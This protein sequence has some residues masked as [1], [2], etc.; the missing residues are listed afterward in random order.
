[1]K[2]IRVGDFCHWPKR[3]GGSPHWKPPYRPAVFDT[4]SANYTPANAMN[5]EDWIG[6]HS[7]IYEA[8]EVVHK[9][10]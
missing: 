5:G 9:N 7:E 10:V 2:G 3:D 8:A 4:T 6:L 1:M